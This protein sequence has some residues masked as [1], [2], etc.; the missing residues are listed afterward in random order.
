MPLEYPFIEL[1]MR[2]G[3]FMGTAKIFLKSPHMGLTLHFYT[4]SFC[5]AISTPDAKF[6]LKIK[7]PLSIGQWVKSSACLISEAGAAVLNCY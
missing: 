6:F 4:A 7:I 5:G 1:G 3:V 2:E